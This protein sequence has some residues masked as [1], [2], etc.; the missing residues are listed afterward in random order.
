MLH[1]IVFLT[2]IIVAVLI[3]HV[4]VDLDYIRIV[5]IV[6]VSDLD[7]LRSLFFESVDRA[8][9]LHLPVFDVTAYAAD[10]VI[11]V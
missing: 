1:V 11:P 7:Q 9:V 6:I 4:V 10:I 5:S 3:I 8:Y 2:R